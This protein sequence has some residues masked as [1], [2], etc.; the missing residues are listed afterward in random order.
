MPTDKERKNIATLVALVDEALGNIAWELVFVDDDSPDGTFEEVTRV[1]ESDPRVC[2]VLRT[3]ERSLAS[4]VI[5]GA[6]EAHGDLV[7]VMDADLQHDPNVLR[8]FVRVLDAGEADLGVG[9]RFME[10]GGAPGL[11]RQRELASTETNALLRHVTGVASTDPLS[12]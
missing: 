9:S 11:S 10:G 6:G 12:G 7:A 5:R 4:A 8:E 1:G 3:H 2:G